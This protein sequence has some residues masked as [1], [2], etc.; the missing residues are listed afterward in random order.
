MPYSPGTANLCTKGWLIWLLNGS[1]P[2]GS[3]EGMLAALWLLW[4]GTK[5]T[6]S[7]GAMRRWSGSKPWLHQS[8]G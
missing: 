8:H 1:A 7:P 5:R 2:A 6:L 3:S 4:V